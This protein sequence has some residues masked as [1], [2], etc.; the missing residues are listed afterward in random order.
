M[1]QGTGTF[2]YPHTGASGSRAALLSSFSPTYACLPLRLAHL[3][4]IFLVLSYM[5][6]FYCIQLPAR[7][8]RSFLA[9][10][11]VGISVCFAH[12]QS[13]SKKW[14]CPGD[15]SS[16]TWSLFLCWDF[17]TKNNLPGTFYMLNKYL[18]TEWLNKHYDICWTLSCLRVRTEPYSPLV[19][20]LQ[21]SVLEA[22]Q[23][24]FLRS[25]QKHLPVV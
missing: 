16:L 14:C 13:I 15:S 23:I 10:G 19:V 18:S 5:Y 4:L 24:P 8:L 21:G 12:I 7:S 3:M 11:G 22:P 25:R 20:L 17:L 6:W 2:S 1:S 9:V